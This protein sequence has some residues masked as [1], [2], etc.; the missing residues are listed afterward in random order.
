MSDQAIIPKSQHEIEFYDD[1]VTA[2]LAPDGTVYVPVRPLCELIGVT[3]QGQ[4]QRINRDPILSELAQGVNVTFA[5]SVDG[6]GGGTQTAICLPLSHL[7]GWL[8]GINANRVK[9][10][11]K[12]ALLRY[13][14]DCYNILYEAFTTGV[15]VRPDSDIMQ[16]TDEA[17]VTY[18]TL[19]QLARIAREHYYLTKRV[20]EHDEQ[21]ADHAKQIGLIQAQLSNPAAYVTQE[22]AQLI[23]SGVKAIATHL[24][25]VSG[26]NEFGAVYGELY[27]RYGV[28]SYKQIAASRYD[29]VM[30][31]LRQWWVELTDG[32]DVPF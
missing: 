22:Q 11:V 12:E 17:A 28:T 24:G 18:R 10:E 26:R 15:S 8:F 13:Q 2:I 19:V 9:P 27:Q 30:T 6:R 23:S 1:K 31:W 32:A 14:K 7:N 16:S 5:P 21:L 20:D 4:R 3:W 25:K 29:E